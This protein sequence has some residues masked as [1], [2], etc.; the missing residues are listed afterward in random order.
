MQGSA[1][2]ILITAATL[3]IAA[4]T[5]SASAQ[6]KAY[7]PGVSDTEIRIGQVMPFSGPVSGLSISSAVQRAYFEMINERGG[8][9]GRKI[10]L[11]SLDDGYNPTKSIEQTRQLVERD[12]VFLIFAPIGTPTNV[13]IQPYLNSKK[14]PQLFVQGGASRFSEPSKS[15]W[16]VP[17][18]ASYKTEGAVYGKYLVAEK[19]NAKIGVL[20][21]NDDLGRDLVAGLKDGLANHASGMIVSEVAFNVT[22]ATI[23][24]QIV[25]LKASGADT[26]FY[27]ASP[28]FAAQAIRKTHELGWRPLKFLTYG[29]A[30]VRTTLTPAGL[31]ASN[32]IL[33]V[34]DKKPL[35][36]PKSDPEIQEYYA[37]LRK[38]VPQANPEQNVEAQA[39]VLSS[40]LV[41]VLEACGDNLTR[42]NVMKQITSLK[43]IPIP[44][45]VPGAFVTMTPSD[46]TLVRVLQL[47]RF[48][49]AKWVPFGI[50]LKL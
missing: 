28:K 13:A 23:D 30:Q 39:Y 5:G 15:P 29:S 25:T 41:K 36:D 24:S 40:L 42:E 45:G 12:E 20:Y 37:F 35:D 33:T 49:G 43:D 32:G 27:F 10:R 3:T 19:P 17:G 31:D 6:T 26:V 16:T 9:N 11:L 38:R 48:D 7:G 50:P 34:A 8:I 21:Q 14:V 18:M 4:P 22:D 47:R 1:I 2:H 46:Y 44:M